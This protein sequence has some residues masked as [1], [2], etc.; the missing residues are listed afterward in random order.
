[1]PKPQYDLDKTYS[2]VPNTRTAE[3]VWYCPH[4]EPLKPLYVRKCPYSRV[5][6]MFYMHLH[7]LT[8]IAY[9]AYTA[10]NVQPSLEYSG[11]PNRQ[12]GKCMLLN[13]QKLRLFCSI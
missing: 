10:Y 4:W 11:V 2:G 12:A 6:N 8:Y 9:T 7:T 13:N 1:M 5:P 3:T